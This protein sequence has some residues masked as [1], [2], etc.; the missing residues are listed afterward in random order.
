MN[1]FTFI[2]NPNAG[3]GAGRK[4]RDRI[5]KAI[6]SRTSDFE[7]IETE[8]PGD[9]TEMARSS[10][11]PNIV[12]VGGDGTVHEVANGIVGTEKTLGVIPAG[13]GNDFIKS[14]QVPKDLNKSIECL[15]RGKTNAIDVGRVEVENGT[16]NQGN[17][18]ISFFVNGLGIGFDAAVAERASHISFASG[19]LLYIVA[20]LQTLG[21]YKSP[22]FSIVVDGR[23]TESRNLLIAVGNGVCAGGGFYLT[24]DAKV[25]DGLLDICL[26]EEIST[27]GV[28]R[29]IPRV[30][31]GNHQ[32][33]SGVKFEKGKSI[34][35]SASHPICVHAD[36][37]I[38]GTDIPR[39][40][41][42]VVPNALKVIVP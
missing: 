3:K 33:Q 29:L 4:L 19:T 8:K 38:L 6:I 11:S 37:E 12:A 17:S 20:V 42:D 23:E 31:Q 25:D 24:P 22:E 10:S 28:L 30:M 34:T 36:G 27:L 21:R 16:S 39:L 18:L 14:I 5:Y 32:R 35:V 1:R 7:L 2:L 41:I 9:A 15:F 26:I 13:S 40:R